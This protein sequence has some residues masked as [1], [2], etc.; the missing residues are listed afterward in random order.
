[1]NSSY[2][3]LSYEQRYVIETMLR[4][5]SN[6]KGIADA[7]GR[8]ASTVTREIA[9]NSTPRGLYRAAHAQ[10]LTDERS[11]DGHHKTKFSSA[12]EKLIREK[13]GEHQWSPEQICGWCRRQGIDMVSHE[14]IYRYIWKEK[15]DGGQLYLQLR[16]GSKKYRKRYGS[17]DRRGGIPG[18][19]SIDE[20]PPEVDAKERV[21]DWEMDLI[22]GPRHK[23]AML[24]IVERSTGFLLM[25]DTKGKKAEE[26][27]R[28]AINAL[29]PYKQWVHTITNDNGKEF[30][31]HL[32]VA[33]RL[34]TDVFFA[35]PYASWERGLNEYTNKLIRQYLPKKAELTN[36]TPKEIGHIVERL[37][38][39]PRKTL[40]YRTPLEVLMNNFDP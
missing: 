37:N 33:E 20:R 19:V 9:R 2:T 34:K 13:L 7:L 8:S 29:A 38:N 10:M 4:S 26:V 22:V 25:A 24:T 16:H 1:M 6:S 12:M 15:K 28:Q 35:H 31:E 32:R 30:A 39:R 23:G 11:R 40:G 21:G 36:V 18:R 5:G 3:R 17:Y 14:R 27:A